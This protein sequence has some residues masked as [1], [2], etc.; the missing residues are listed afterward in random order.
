MTPRLVKPIAGSTDLN[1]DDQDDASTA[2]AKSLAEKVKQEFSVQRGS[3]AQAPFHVDRSLTLTPKEPTRLQAKPSFI[4]MDDDEHMPIPSTWRA[5]PAPEPQT[6][7]F[8]RQLTAGLIGFVLGLAMV[9]P[10]VLW[11]TGH[12]GA[13]K[14]TSGLA[15]ALADR[16]IKPRATAS[17]ATASAPVLVATP[18]PVARPAAAAADNFAQ[19]EIES[20]LKRAKEMISEGNMVRARQIL[21]DRLL[22]DNPQAAYALAETFDPNILAA[23]GAREVRAEVERA[24]TLYGKALAGGVEAARNRLQALN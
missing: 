15:T 9:I 5:L 21:D 11:L 18:Q 14:P 23:T 2:A 19:A 4:D 1:G 6:S 12:F 16:D 20:L 13:V 3:R 10:T 24:R 8:M 17:A 22:A 7:W